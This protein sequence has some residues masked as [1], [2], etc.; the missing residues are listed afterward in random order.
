VKILSEKCGVALVR[1]VKDDLRA[2]GAAFERRAADCAACDTPGA[3]CLDEHFVNVRITRLEAAAIA[4]V[5]ERLPAIR[6]AGAEERIRNSSLRLAGSD[7]VDTFACP[8]YEKGTGCLVHDEA[9]PVPCIVHA[10]YDKREEVP[11]D[12][13]Q[14]AAELAIDRLNSRIYGRSTAL[15]PLPIAVQAAILRT[16]NM[17]AITSPAKNQPAT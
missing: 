14:D 12:D 2:D 4:Q 13:L 3:C 15:E 9:K 1:H 17:N 16:R 6:R 5:I 7:D 10:C 8:L 11:P